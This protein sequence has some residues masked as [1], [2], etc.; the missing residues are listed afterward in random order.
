M[1]G[2]TDNTGS[3]QYNQNLSERRAKSVADYL[4]TRAVAMTR[5]LVQGMAFSQ[6][7]ADNASSAG[8]AA[9]RRVELYILPKV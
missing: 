4:A 8:R 7:I 2:H 5:Q 3:Q 6:P 9:N 1:T